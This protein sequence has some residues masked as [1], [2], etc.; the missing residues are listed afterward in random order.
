VQSLFNVVLGPFKGL[1]NLE[2]LQ[3]FAKSIWHPSIFG[4]I[5]KIVLQQFDIQLGEF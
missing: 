3:E 1:N 2:H 4:K 5:G